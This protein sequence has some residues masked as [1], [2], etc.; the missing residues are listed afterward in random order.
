MA[1][2]EVLQFFPTEHSGYD[3]LLGYLNSV[4]LGLKKS[5]D[6]ES[7]SWWQVLNEPYPE[8]GGNYIESS[9]SAMFTWGLL[10]AVDLGYLDRDDYLDTAKDAFHSLTR[11]FV[12]DEANGSIVLNSTVAECGLSSSNVTFE[13]SILSTNKACLIFL[14]TTSVEQSLTMVKMVWDRLC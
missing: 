10:K 14:S 8:R 12:E 2:V 7:G 5:R 4:A 3:K 9:G 1:L 13:V 11:N 6:A